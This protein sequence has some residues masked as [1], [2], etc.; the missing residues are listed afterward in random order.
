MRSEFSWKNSSWNLV[1][2]PNGISYS[3]IQ[4]IIDMQSVAPVAERY[5]VTL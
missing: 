5:L 4:H 2:F 3:I 1:G